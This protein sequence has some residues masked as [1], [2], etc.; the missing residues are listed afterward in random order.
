[1]GIFAKKSSA[2]C[3]LQNDFGP[4]CFLGASCGIKDAR[5]TSSDT[6][7]HI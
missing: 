3:Q 7:L 4:I 6:K 2:M 1:M 5:F